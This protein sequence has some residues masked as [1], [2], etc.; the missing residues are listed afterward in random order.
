MVQART[1]S[2]LFYFKVSSD[3]NVFKFRQI[4][5]ILRFI[6]HIKLD[7][8]WKKHK[9]VKQLFMLFTH[10]LFIY[11][12]RYFSNEV[13]IVC[14]AIFWVI[15]LRFRFDWSERYGSVD[16]RSFSSWNG[17]VHIRFTYNVSFSSL[18]FYRLL[19]CSRCCLLIMTTTNKNCNDI[20]M[21]SEFPW[22]HKIHKNEK[23]ARVNEWANE[24]TNERMTYTQNT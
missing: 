6:N 15:L 21:P 14:A 11:I 7:Q 12:H 20:T 2:I 24:R 18:F 17:W 1:F 13:I 19:P 9:I 16:F 23:R 8:K 10:L 5:L 4:H 3:W 22:A